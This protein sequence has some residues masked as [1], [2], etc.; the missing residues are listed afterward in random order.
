[1]VLGPRFRAVV[2]LLVF[3]ASAAFIAPASHAQTTEDVH[4]AHTAANAS[5]ERTKPL[6]K[7][8]ELVLVPVTVTDAADHAIT[9][10]EKNDFALYEDGRPQIISSFSSED[11]PLSLGVIFDTSK[12]MKDKIDRTREAVASFFTSAD[13]KDEFFLVTFSDRP[14]LLADFTSPG[15]IQGALTQAVPRGHTALLD[16]IYLGLQHVHDGQY[17][18]KALLIISDGGDNSSRYTASEIKDIVRESDVQIYAI[19]IFDSIFKTPEEQGGE[20]LL[21]AV[22]EAT[23]GRTFVLHNARELPAIVA[24]I[25]LELRSQYVLGYHPSS[26]ARD[27]QWHKIQV[28]LAAPSGRHVHARTGYSAPSE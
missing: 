14:L 8:V 5:H 11:G 25:S 28:K 27:G 26:R 24:E 13:P 19:G 3:S 9:G 15:N 17:P 12:S 20:R 4:I 7:N 1:M 16:A 18:R 21:R 6:L 10:L 23:G 2:S 22:T